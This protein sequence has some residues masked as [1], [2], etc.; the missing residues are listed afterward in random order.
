G[1]RLLLDRRLPLA[2]AITQQHPVAL[3]LESPHGSGSDPA[4]FFNGHGLSLV[5]GQA[6]LLRAGS[7]PRAAIE[8]AVE[9]GARA[10]VVYGTDLPA[11]G[12]G[13]DEAVGAPVASA[14]A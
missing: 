4:D 13:L 12:L 3:E 14:P 8:N 11:G 6:A 9:A 1:L 10:V 2:G 7:D 5:A